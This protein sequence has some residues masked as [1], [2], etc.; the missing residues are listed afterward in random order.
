MKD[1]VPLLQ[2]GVWVAIGVIV[3][4]AF[5]ADLAAIRRALV[6]RL[7]SGSSLKVGFLEIGAKLTEVQKEV[8]ALQEK[9]G[10]LFLLTMSPGMYMNLRKLESGHFGPFAKSSAL[11]RELRHLRDIGYI[12]IESISQLPSEGA[13]LS[14]FVDVTEIGRTFIELREGSGA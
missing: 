6:A 7:E 2:T 13:E 8:G 14:D 11:E 5:R 9:I 1:Y 3:L 4:F 12:D 10:E